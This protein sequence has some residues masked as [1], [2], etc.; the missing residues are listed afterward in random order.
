MGKMFA[1]HVAAFR[2]SLYFDMQ[3]DHVLKQFNFDPTQGSDPGFRSE[4]TFDMLYLL[5]L[6]VD[7]KFQ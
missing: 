6:C 4:I 2:D 7:A 3:H 1:I 5:Y